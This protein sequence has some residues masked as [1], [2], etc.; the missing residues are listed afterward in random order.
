MDVWRWRSVVA[1]RVIGTCVMLVRSVMR[2]V[3]VSWLIVMLV[4]AS[5]VLRA[6][7][8]LVVVV[9][10]VLRVHGSHVSRSLGY[11]LHRLRVDVHLR[12]N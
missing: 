9:V 4:M 6:V 12:V 2:L 7:V 5:V 3:V 8:R 10:W 11:H 1:V